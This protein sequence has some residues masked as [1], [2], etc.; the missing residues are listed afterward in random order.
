MSEKEKISPE[1]EM[2]T[3]KQNFLANMSHEIRTPLN[4]IIGLSRQL[5]KS[6]LTPQ[7]YYFAE[8]IDKASKE[9]L[10]IV[11]DILDI[12]KID[13]GQIRIEATNFDIHSV[14]HEVQDFIKLSVLEKKLDLQLHVEENINKNLIG[15]PVRLS[16]VLINLATNAVKFTEKGSVSIHTTLIKDT[17][18]IQILRFCINDTGIGIEEEYL[19][20]IFDIF[21][22]EDASIT[23]K[24]RGSGLGMKISKSL[25][26]LMGGTIT[27][28]SQKSIGTKVCIEIPF[29][30]K[31]QIDTIAKTTYSFD[32]S[33]LKSLKILSVDD[34]EMNRL[35]ASFVLGPLVSTIVEAENGE[36]A[37]EILKENQDFDL[38]LMDIQMPVMGGFEAVDKI[39]NELG[40]KI[41]VL[42]LTASALKSEKD[43]CISRGF[44]GYLSKP[45]EEEEL[46]Y[47]V[48]QTLHH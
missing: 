40:L 1:Y 16:Q 33:E 29:Q 34:S 4:A 38:I 36:E 3:A 44:S 6:N 12:N 22:Q 31:P 13:S 28:D 20:K 27:I 5:L 30:K 37:L 2:A 15:D 26:E 7:Q 24:Y 48:I 11:N 8:N 32:V 19:K 14:V 21:S 10:V 9:L 39:R 23:R 46:I 45:F 18:D 43:F 25:V 35:L 41:P 47:E 42:A 17:D